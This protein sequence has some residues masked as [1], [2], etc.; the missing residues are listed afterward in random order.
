MENHKI[1]NIFPMIS[2][3]E[4]N[5]LKQDIKENGLIE[6]I[7]LYEN[8]ILDGRNRYKA[9]SESGIVPRFKEFDGEDALKYVISKNLHRRHLNESQ[10]GLVASRLANLSHGGDRQSKPPIGGLLCLSPP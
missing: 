1:A 3:I 2:E 5:R 6:E 8:K 4:F 7:E 9:C 10:R